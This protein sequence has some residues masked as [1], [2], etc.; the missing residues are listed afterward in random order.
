MADVLL[1][2]SDPIVELIETV[3]RQTSVEN[4]LEQDVSGELTS[5]STNDSPR[6]E[7]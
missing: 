3:T 2:L 6:A 7:L 1:G 4:G 5:T